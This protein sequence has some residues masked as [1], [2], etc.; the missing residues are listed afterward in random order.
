LCLPAL[1]CNVFSFEAKAWLASDPRL[2]CGPARRDETGAAPSTAPGVPSVRGLLGL[3][4]CGLG[5][6]VVL[7]AAE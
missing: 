2:V 3:F 5:K 6:L 1:A 7:G 4:A